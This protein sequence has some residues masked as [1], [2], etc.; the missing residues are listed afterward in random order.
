M[1]TLPQKLNPIRY[2]RLTGLMYLLIAIVGGYSIGYLPSRLFLDLDAKDFLLHVR[3]N[4]NDLRL[5]MV[6]DI[7]VIT[8]EFVLTGMLFR[9][10]KSVDV[11]SATIAA[12][13]RFAMGVIMSV[14]VLFYAIPLALLSTSGWD[15]GGDYTTMVL[16]LLKSHELGVMAWQWCFAIHLVALGYLVYKCGFLP[17]VLGLLMAIGSIGYG[18]DSFMRLLSLSNGT[19]EIVF[20]IFLA[21]AVIGELGLTFWLLIKRSRYNPMERVGE[22]RGLGLFV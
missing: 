2:A 19:S 8:L 13:T 7:V 21:I 1:N 4:L 10:F 3:N 11:T 6:G 9:M 17:K 18:G 14:N 5:A 12:A 22:S 20:G 16:T 15:I